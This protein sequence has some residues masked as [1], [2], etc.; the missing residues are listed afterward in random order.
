MVGVAHRAGHQSTFSLLAQV[1]FRWQHV[2]ITRV[3]SLHQ[4]C[5]DASAVVIIRRQEAKGSLCPALL[6]SHCRLQRWQ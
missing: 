5:F 6:A 2:G 4:D 3:D 1:Q